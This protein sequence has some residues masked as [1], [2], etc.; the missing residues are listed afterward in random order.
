MKKRIIALVLAAMLFLAMPM[1]AFAD[2]D[3]P[4][5]LEYSVIVSNYEG[6]ELYTYRYYEA[7]DE[8]LFEAAD[9]AP[10]GTEMVVYGEYEENGE[11][12]CNVAYNDEFYYV[13]LSDVLPTEGDVPASAGYKLRLTRTA[14]VFDNT[15]VY[16]RRG[17]SVAYDVITNRI[18]NGTKLSFE[19]TDVEYGDWAYTTYN[20]TGGWV[21]IR[22]YDVSSHGVALYFDD[23]SFFADKALTVMDGAKLF[24]KPTSAASTVSSAI[25][26]QTPLKLSYMCES[27]EGTWAYT[28]HNGTNGWLLIGGFEGEVASAHNKNRIYVVED[29]GVALYGKLNDLS[30]KLETRIPA[31]TILE[32]EYNYDC[33]NGDDYYSWYKVNYEGT[34]AWFND[35]EGVLDE[36]EWYYSVKS[37]EGVTLYSKPSTNSQAVGTVVPVGTKLASS[38]YYYSDDDIG[39]VYVTFNNETAGWVQEALVEDLNEEVHPIQSAADP[40]AQGE[41]GPGEDESKAGTQTG[42]NDKADGKL[43]GLSIT[44]L[45]IICAVGAGVLAV[46]AIV[47]LILVNKKKNK[48]VN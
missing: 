15:E 14:Y 13:R 7:V 26:A 24:A 31:G 32:Y 27:T 45:L 46:T 17:P 23:A 37:P 3:G 42:K 1:T 34:E 35:D 12:F 5:M 30:S 33:N 28:S 16:L 9:T 4:A 48:P 18:P 22:N 39:W 20:G 10:Y 25:P 44:S 11:R 2:A 38:F 40:G 47:V 36:Y 6:A 21:Q 43:F 41:A 29:D 19:Y 8:W